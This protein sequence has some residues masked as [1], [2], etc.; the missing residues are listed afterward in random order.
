MTPQEHWI[1]IVVPANV[2][3][4]LF[5]LAARRLEDNRRFS[6]RRTKEPSLLQGLIACRRCGHAFFRAPKKSRGGGSYIYYRC[7]GNNYKRRHGRVCHNRP[8][9]QDHLDAL[10]WQHIVQLIS[11]PALIRCELDRRL[12]EHRKSP[13]ATMERSRLQQELKRSESAIKRLVAAYEEE[14]V[15]LDELRQ[16]ARTPPQTQD[17]QRRD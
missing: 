8:V 10:V 7:A 2:S 13:A 4:E 9:R 6:A 11:Q 14:L 12:E 1:Q 5:Q 17:R 3:E 15:S 16:H